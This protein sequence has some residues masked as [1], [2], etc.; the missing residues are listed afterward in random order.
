M[1]DHGGLGDD[2]IW[3][4]AGSIFDESGLPPGAIACRPLQ[5]FLAELREAPVDAAAVDAETSQRIG[6]APRCRGSAISKRAL[7]QGVFGG[8]GF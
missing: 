2:F 6:F 8:L 4:K 7:D 5:G 3:Q 1:G